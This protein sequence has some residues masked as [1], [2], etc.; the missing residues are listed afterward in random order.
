MCMS[1]NYSDQLSPMND[2]T[3]GNAEPKSGESWEWSKEGDTCLTTLDNKKSPKLRMLEGG[4]I[5][6]TSLYI[7]RKQTVPRAGNKGGEVCLTTLY[8]AGKQ[9]VPKAACLREVTYV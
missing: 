2:A 8:I 7:T 4:E 5:C 6:F 9:K 1:S 3:A